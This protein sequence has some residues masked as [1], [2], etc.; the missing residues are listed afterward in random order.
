MIVS[1]DDFLVIHGQD[2]EAWAKKHELEPITATCRHCGRER[3][4]TI[5]FA[6]ADGIR[7]LMAPPCPC[8]SQARTY[9]MVRDPRWG[10]LLDPRLAAKRKRR[11]KRPPNSRAGQ[12]TS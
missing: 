8:G 9:C 2:P 3:R 5:P 10:D 7:G 11:R 6:A 12:G 1:S 4:T